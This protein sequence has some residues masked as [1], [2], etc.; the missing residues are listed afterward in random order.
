MKLGIYISII[1]P[2]KTRLDIF[3]FWYKNKLW[4]FQNALLSFRI[5]HKESIIPILKSN[6][7]VI[8]NNCDIET[9]LSFH[10][11]NSFRN[12][13]IGN[14]CHIGKNCFFDLRDKVE[15]GNNVVVS[16]DVSFITHIDM[17]KSS[18]RDRYPARHMPVIIGNDVYI[19][20]GSKILMGVNIGQRAFIAAGALVNRDVECSTLVGGIPAKIIKTISK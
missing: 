7:A 11:C 12:L 5:L 13:I 3:R 16:M 8:G 18:L 10:N 1:R 20:T 15:I 4:G 14:N 17:N 6:G 9:G 19:G 2:F